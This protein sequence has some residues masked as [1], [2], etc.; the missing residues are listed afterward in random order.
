MCIIAWWKLILYWL[1]ICL[2]SEDNFLYG[3]HVR[4]NSNCFAS[5]LISQKVVNMLLYICL[6]SMPNWSVARI[7][8]NPL[9]FN[10]IQLQIK[11]HITKLMEWN[12]IGIYTFAFNSL[13]DQVRH[14]INMKNYN[15]WN[16]TNSIKIQQYLYMGGLLEGLNIRELYIWVG[17]WKG[18]T[19]E[20]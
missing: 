1:C 10:S 19:L 11:N 2:K 8:I 9:Q 12:N 15:F 3:K 18:W 16:I 5:I 14:N 7:K 4:E 17:S 6:I 13:I 20:N